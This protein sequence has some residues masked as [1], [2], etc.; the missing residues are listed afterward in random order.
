MEGADADIMCFGHKSY[1][2][3]PPTEVTENLHY[4]HAINIGSIQ[5]GF[6]SLT[7]ILEKT[8]LM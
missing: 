8:K 3:I 4:R 5:R 2:R 6:L 1:H 7:E